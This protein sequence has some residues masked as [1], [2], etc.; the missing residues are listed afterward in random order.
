MKI[1]YNLLFLCLVTCGTLESSGEGDGDAPRRKRDAEL[2]STPQKGLRP[3]STKAREKR[4][5]GLGIDNTPARAEALR[6]LEESGD[7]QLAND[8]LLELLRRQSGEGD[9]TLAEINEHILRIQEQ[10][11]SSSGVVNHPASFAGLYKAAKSLLEDS[12][13]FV[14]VDMHHVSRPQA[15]AKRHA[16]GTFGEGNYARASGGHLLGGSQGWNSVPGQRPLSCVSA[17]NGGECGE[18]GASAVTFK[19]AGRKAITKTA[20]PVGVDEEG[21]LKRVRKSHAIAV[22]K[23][24]A[25]LRMV[26]GTG[27]IFLI[28]GDGSQDEKSVD[29]IKTMYPF[30]VLSC[31]EGGGSSLVTVS[32]RSLQLPDGTFSSLANTLTETQ[33]EDCLNRAKASNNRLYFDFEDKTTPLIIDVTKE[34]HAA[35]GFTGRSI[36]TYSMWVDKSCEDKAKEALGVCTISQKKDLLEKL[37]ELSVK[38]DGSPGIW[39]S[40][41]IDSDDSSAAVYHSQLIDA[42]TR[43]F[44]NKLFDD[45]DDDD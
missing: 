16:D 20:W 4:L 2:L 3:E 13:A 26:P 33:L 18:G 27:E 34:V 35:L 39:G 12:R 21:L 24:K 15:V 30:P 37:K 32:E 11:T 36:N 6:K 43:E 38:E 14:A 7:S 8:I 44:V 31:P 17:S 25:Q 41:F 45:D 40:L 28:T 29:F 9:F 10:H 1:L 22:D 42:L 19:P 5:R 23:K